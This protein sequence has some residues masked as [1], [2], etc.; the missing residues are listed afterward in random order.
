MKHLIFPLQT[1]IAL[2]N[3]VNGE[4]LHLLVKGSKVSMITVPKG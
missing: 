3:A 2:P 4:T 1:P